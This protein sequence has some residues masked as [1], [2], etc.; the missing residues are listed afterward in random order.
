[1]KK[2]LKINTPTLAKHMNSSVVISLTVSKSFMDVM[3]LY[4]T[5]SSNLNDTMPMLTKQFGS[6]VTCTLEDGGGK[7]RF[8]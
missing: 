3:T 4:L 2:G 7:Y 6:M 1:M 8:V 5:S